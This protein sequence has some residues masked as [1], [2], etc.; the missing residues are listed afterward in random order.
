MWRK[1]AGEWSFYR[2]ARE[3]MVTARSTIEMVA[4]GGLW[5]GRGRRPVQRGLAVVRDAVAQKMGVGRCR[6]HVRDL[7]AMA[8]GV[9]GS[10]GYGAGSRD[11]WRLGGRGGYGDH[12]GRRRGQGD[13]WNGGNGSCSVRARGR[14]H[15]GYGVNVWR[16]LRPARCVWRGKWS[17]QSTRMISEIRH[18]Y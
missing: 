17:G 3:R 10:G 8:D 14:V 5:P 6:E 16:G 9:D 7:T 13:R 12:A 15:A 1:R 11:R 18:G 2:G 4:T